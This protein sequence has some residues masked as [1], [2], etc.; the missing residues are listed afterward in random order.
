METFAILLGA[1]CVVP[2]AFV[3]T[4]TMAAAYRRRKFKPVVL[5]TVLTVLWVPIFAATAA[6]LYWMF[7]EEPYR[8]EH[9]LPTEG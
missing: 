1:C 3:V 8:I 4:I 2:L 7:I 9:G 6:E 5:W